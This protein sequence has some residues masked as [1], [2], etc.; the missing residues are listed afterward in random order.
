MFFFQEEGG[1][2]EEESVE[3]CN[4]HLVDSGQ[5]LTPHT[6]AVTGMLL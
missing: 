4:A 6:E 5:L 3:E 2:I 1:D